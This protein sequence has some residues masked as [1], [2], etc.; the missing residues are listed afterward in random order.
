MKRLVI[1]CAICLT[2]NSHAQNIDT[3]VDT[4]VAHNPQLRLA[5]Q[6]GVTALAEL[7]AENGLEPTEVEYSPFFT[8]GMSG[9]TS[10]ELVVSQSFRL[11]WVYAS[12]NRLT[13]TQAEANRLEIEALTQDIRIAARNLCIE[14]VGLNNTLAIAQRRMEI[15][16]SLL[17]LYQ[18]AM[19]HGNAT[20]LDVNRIR[21]ERMEVE[22]TL[23]DTRTAR[24]KAL[25]LLCEMNDGQPVC[26]DNAPWPATMPD[27]SLHRS[28]ANDTRQQAANHQIA[29]AR[30]REK[31]TRS[32]LLPSLTVGYR[33]NTDADMASHGVLIGGSVP[34]FGNKKARTIARHQREEA[35]TQARITQNE[36]E[37]ERLTLQ[38]ELQLATDKLRVTDETVVRETLTMLRRSLAAGQISLPDYLTQATPLYNILEE[39]VAILT[40]YHQ[41]LSSLDR[42]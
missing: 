40:L 27:Q 9:M 2:A 32:E 5:R 18:T 4:V 24:E 34:L 39:R 20:A 25:Y 35:E 21:M 38:S 29:V 15:A 31:V 30:Q 33:R 13:H 8:R 3:V 26:L 7:K 6:Q 12:H 1:V 10:S 37:R 41:T 23:L 16:D 19:Q 17:A 14:V 11:P 22:T 28:T 42:K 36:I